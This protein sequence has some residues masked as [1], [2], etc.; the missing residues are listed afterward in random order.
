D[1]E[2]HFTVVVEIGE[3]CGQ[4]VISILIADTRLVAHI[5]EGTVAVV[6]KQVVTLAQQTARSAHNLEPTK[7]ASWKRYGRGPWNWRALQVVMDI[8]RNK[9]VQASIAIVVAEGR[10]G[11]P[12]AER[13]TRFF[14]HVGE[15]PIMIIVIE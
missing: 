8:S 4:P 13:D 2:I 12:I 3:D 6:V 11:R 10:S 14:G 7:F 1:D 15:S 5:G 9:Q